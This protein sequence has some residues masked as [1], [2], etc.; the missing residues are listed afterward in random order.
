MDNNAEPTVFV[1]DDDEEIVD[2][3]HDEDR[4]ADDIDH[5]S[6]EWVVSLQARF[7]CAWAAPHT[8]C[9]TTLPVRRAAS[10]MH[11]AGGCYARALRYDMDGMAQVWPVNREE[12]SEERACR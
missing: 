4:P 8:P 7:T 9:L 12:R 11:G 1:P 3:W 5:S 10:R 2:E 6:N